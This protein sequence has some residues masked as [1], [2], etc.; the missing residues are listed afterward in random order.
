MET[1]AFTALYPDYF[2]NSRLRFNNLHWGRFS[3]IHSCSYSY[4]FSFSSL[5]LLFSQAWNACFDWLYLSTLLPF[6]VLLLRTQW[7]QWNTALFCEKIHKVDGWN[8]EVSEWK[9]FSLDEVKKEDVIIYNW[10]PFFRR[11]AIKS[12]VRDSFGKGQDP[13]ILYNVEEIKG[14]FLI[15]HATHVKWNSSGETGVWPSR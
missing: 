2:G 4:I 15:T 8:F 6:A 9:W 11:F 14:K 13:D 1:T 5:N 7:V 12:K 3:L 10:T